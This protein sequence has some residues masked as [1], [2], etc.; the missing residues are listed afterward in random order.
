MN[1]FQNL[2]R[3]ICKEKNIKFNIV[4]KDWIMILDNGKKK[5]YISGYKFD[6]NDHA[7]GQIC[8]DKYALYDTL[9]LFNIPVIEHYILFKKYNKEDVLEYAKK[10]GFNIVIKTNVGTCGNDMYHVTNENDLFIYIDELLSKNSSI[11]ICPYYE[12]K[13]EYRTIV[14]NNIPKLS[15]GKKKPVVI[16]D[17]KSTIHEL[18]CKFNNYYFENISGDDKLNKILPLNDVYEYNWQFNLSKGALPYFIDDEELKKT[19]QNLSI[20]VSKI[21]NLEFA[22]IDIVQLNTDEFLILEIN[23]GVMMNNF[24]NIM[25]NGNDI[26]KKIYEEAIDKMFNE[27]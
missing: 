3:D 13:N 6:L 17:G 1:N 24:M 9:K 27:S 18:L 22:S 19:I 25:P 5:R 16:G 8:D 21:L 26:A 14:L 11:S 4:S 10:Y 12:I 15:Y 2:I 23:S 7:T 20:K